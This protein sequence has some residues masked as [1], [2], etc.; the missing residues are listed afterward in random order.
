MTQQARQAPLHA[1]GACCC[2]RT[3]AC[4]RPARHAC[5]WQHLLQC[6]PGLDGEPGSQAALMHVRLPQV[7]I[8]EGAGADD[9]PE[10]ELDDDPEVAAALDTSNVPLLITVAQVRC[11]GARPACPARVCSSGL[12]TAIA[13]SGPGSGCWVRTAGSSPRSSRHVWSGA[14]PMLRGAGRAEQTRTWRSLPGSELL[15]LMST[16]CM[17]TCRS[18]APPAQLGGWAWQHLTAGR[19]CLSACV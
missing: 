8:T 1:G 16:C 2:T 11:S 13:P 9:P 6:S 3:D 14:C 10:I 15:G 4:S 19:W 7:Q 5:Q 12:W 18:A 17:H